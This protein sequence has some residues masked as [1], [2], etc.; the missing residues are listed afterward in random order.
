MEEHCA[1]VGMKRTLYI[2]NEGQI[3]RK[4]N[5]I[6][7]TTLDDK[8]RDVPI[9]MISDI[10]VMTDI[11]LNTNFLNYISQFGI[12]IHFY[13]YYSYYSGSYI[14]K[15]TLISGRLVVNQVKAYIDQSHRLEIAK[16]IIEAA[17]FNIYRNLRYYNSRGK[18]LSE[19]MRDIEYLRNQ[20]PSVESIPELMGVEGNIRKI[21]YGTWK[22]IIVQ[23]IDFE[24][25]VMNP[26]N[27]MVNSLISFVNSV[28]YARVVSEIYK[29]ALDPSISFLHEP[30]DRRFS[31]SLDIA[32]I[33]KP[34]I[35][36]RLIFSMLNKKQI[37]KDCFTEGLEYL[38]LKKEYSKLVMELLDERMAKTIKHR[39][40]NKSVSYRYLMRLE[41]YKLIKDLMGEK[42]YE[43]FKIWW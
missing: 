16:S 5:T 22:K 13:N 2:Y 10:F 11:H 14:P 24:K 8:K 1:I 15:K 36:D 4:D 26:P 28:I 23:D 43:G 21:Y 35:G 12:N 25:R 30:G 17:S 9:E 18:D 39:D 31:L 32:E 29:T 42:K 40:L 38:H 19:E 27:N 37:D 7:F 34:L 33:F 20:I 41:C 3:S 6:R